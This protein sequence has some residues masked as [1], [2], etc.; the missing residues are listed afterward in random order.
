MVSDARRGV[1]VMGEA[2]YGT[3]QIGTPEGVARIALTKTHGNHSLRTRAR[4]GGL[5]QWRPSDSWLLR[6]RWRPVGATASSERRVV[7]VREGGAEVERLILEN[8][9]QLA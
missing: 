3:I 7:A 4:A 8:P 9:C 2:L 1:L 6:L 5:R